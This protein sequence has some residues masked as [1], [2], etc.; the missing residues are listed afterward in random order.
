M[1][2]IYKQLRK[3]SVSSNGINGIIVFY[4]MNKYIFLS[5]EDSMEKMGMWDITW[6]RQGD[7][8][9]TGRYIAFHGI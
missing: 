5:V 4:P 9:Q 2:Y 6:D 8:W 3:Q 7:T 1:V